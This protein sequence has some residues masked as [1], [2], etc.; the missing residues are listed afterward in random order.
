MKCFNKNE[1]NCW[2][3]A[4]TT[5]EMS[6]IMPLIFFLLLLIL[7]VV[8]YYHDKIILNGIASETAVTGSQA[9]RRMDEAGKINLEEFFRERAG[10]KLLVFSGYEISIYTSKE[11]IRVQAFASE[12]GM[13]L[14][15]E[16]RAR[17]MNTEERLRR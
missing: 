5:I 15:I 6:Y 16:Q 14:N 2:L 13:Q 4:N 7:Y 1:G 11:E 17:I 9:E 12:G 10:N 8:F 3:G